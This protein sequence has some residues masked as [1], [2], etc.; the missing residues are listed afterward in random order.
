MKVSNREWE[1]AIDGGLVRIYM[2]DGMLGI[3][4]LK[5]SVW[6]SQEVGKDTDE[7]V[8]GDD[9]GLAYL[10]LPVDRAGCFR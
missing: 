2:W 10:R 1:P 7:I 8:I 4:G 3:S 6:I 5:M 9:G